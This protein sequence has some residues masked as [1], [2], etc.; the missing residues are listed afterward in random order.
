MPRSSVSYRLSSPL[1]PTE[2]T[3]VRPKT[4]ESISP[5]GYTLLA[6]SSNEIPRSRA[7]ISKFSV[8][9]ERILSTVSRLTW[10]LRITEAS[11]LFCSRFSIASGSASRR[12]ASAW[13]KAA[14]SLT[15]WGLAVTIYAVADRA[16][17]SPLQSSIVPLRAFTIPSRVHCRTPRAVSAS[18]WFSV[19]SPI[20]IPTSANSSVSAVSIV[21]NRFR[22]TSPAR[23]VFLSGGSRGGKA[24]YRLP[25][26]TAAAAAVSF[27][28]KGRV[29]GAWTATVSAF[30]ASIICSLWDAS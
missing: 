30:M 3:L 17:T 8:R 2:S 15:C 27:S 13:E 21:S 9:R 18:L 26:L 4:W 22:V 24:V 10:R 5:L 7:F 20:R 6:S 19:R 29:S 28:P 12:G 1:W 14:S 11:F 16:S 25:V 23:I